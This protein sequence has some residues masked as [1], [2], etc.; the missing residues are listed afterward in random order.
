MELFQGPSGSGKTWAA[1][2]QAYQIDPTF[3]VSKQ[4]VF[5]IRGLMKLINDQHFKERIWKI[6]IADEFQT[7]TGNRNWQSVQNKMMN[8]LVSTFRHQNIVLYFCCPYRDFFG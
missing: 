7:S 5:D 1:L 4:L 3:D 8:Y 6:V 2:S